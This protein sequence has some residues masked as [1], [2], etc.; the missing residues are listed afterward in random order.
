[1]YLLDLLY[2]IYL[3]IYNEIVVENG[4]R[5]ISLTHSATLVKFQEPHSN[6]V[7]GIRSVRLMDRC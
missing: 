5:R 4:R 7:M 2:V 6:Y 1:M 3:I